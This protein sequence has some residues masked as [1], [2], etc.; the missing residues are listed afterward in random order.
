MFG[1]LYITIQIKNSTIFIFI[2]YYNVTKI[3]FTYYDINIL[4]MIKNYV[5]SYFFMIYFAYM[6]GIIMS[7]RIESDGRQGT[8]DF[9]FP[10]DPERVESNNDWKGCQG[11]CD[12]EES[13][14]TT[15]WI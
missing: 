7:K 12:F 14:N 8:N 13:F 11:Y 5:I 1:N 4:E 3:K 2:H 9:D 15:G 6:R 10:K